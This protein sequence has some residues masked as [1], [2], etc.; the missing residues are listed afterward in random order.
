MDLGVAHYECGCISD[1][2]GDWIGRNG[3]KVFRPENPAHNAC[4]SCGDEFELVSVS[5]PESLA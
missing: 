2:W 5:E 4:P 1:V 3:V